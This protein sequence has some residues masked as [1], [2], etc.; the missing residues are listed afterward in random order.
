MS[1]D[2][3]VENDLKATYFPFPAP[4]QGAARRLGALAWCG[5]LGFCLLLAASLGACAAFRSYDRELERPLTFASAGRV[6]QAIQELTAGTRGRRDLLYRLELGE[7]LRLKGDYAGSQKAWLAAD[8]EVRAWEQAALLQP[9]RLAGLLASYAINDKLGPYEGHDYEKVLLTTRIAINHLALGDWESARVAIK[10]THEREAVIAEL[11]ARQYRELEE[12]AR[13]RGARLD[14]RELSGYPVR[15]IEN[16]EVNALRNGYQASFSHY[17]AGFVYEA[18][19]E[20]SLAAAGYRQA[21]ELQPGAPLL[22]EAL[23]GL[24][25]RASSSDGRTDVL[26]VV[27]TGFAP[28]RRSQQFHLPIAAGRTWVLA[29]VSF[30]ILEAPTAGFAPSEIRIEG[31]EAAVPVPITSVEL[32]ARRALQDEMPS[33]MFRAFLRSAGKAVAQAQLRLKAQQEKNVA[34]E[35]AAFALTVGSAVTESA[36]ERGWR[37]LPARISIARSRLPPGEHALT[38][39]TPGGPRS[40]RVHVTGRHAVVGLRFVGGSLFE[41]TACSPGGTA[42]VRPAAEAPSHPPLREERSDASDSNDHG[43]GDLRPP[44]GLRGEEGF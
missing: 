10:Q 14:V 32:M 23:A 2:R 40:L 6:D 13:R 33:L 37:T 35:L 17:L 29:S 20:P 30:P 42:E 24:E 44:G 36:D 39:A 22:E 38:V 41:L 16:A 12:E 18:L 5:R 21:I 43:T 11:R 15:T 28:A 25:S 7:L 3:G 4:T 34:A 31:F 9:L 8:A 19:G 27:E 26:F 1:N